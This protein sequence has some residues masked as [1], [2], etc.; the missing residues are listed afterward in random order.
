MT[1]PFYLKD[2]DYTG[3]ECSDSV[4]NAVAPIAGIT[5][6]ELSEKNPD[7]LIF[8][9]SLGDNDDGI[10]DQTLITLNGGK[11]QTGNVL[12]FFG[13]NDIRFFIRS[14]F[15]ESDKQFFL[16]Y[17]LQKVFGINVLNLQTG[18]D[19]NDV[20]DFYLLLFP[21]CL[22]NALR[23]GL[24]KTYRRFSRNDSHLRGTID[25]SR[26]LKENSP[27]KGII[28]YQMRERTADNALTQL[29]RHTIEFIRSNPATASILS[30]KD[31]RLATDEIVSATP[32][33]V[34]NDRSKIIAQ[35]L[36][37][38]RHPYF[39]EYTTLQKLCLKILRH[40]TL[41]FESSDEKTYGIIFDAAWLW[42]EYLA[43]LLKENGFTHPRNKL[44][45]G[46][47]PVYTDGYKVFPDFLSIDY[48]TIIDAKYKKLDNGVSREDRYQMISY[49]HI[50]KADEG[51]FAFPAQ[52]DNSFSRMLQG[53]GG[54]V[55][56]K[57]FI[58]PKEETLTA[59]AAEMKNSEERFKESLKNLF[60]Q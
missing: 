32:S 50:T 28:A 18:I 23:Q 54:T 44:R 14:R 19:Q 3:I 12:G 39:T 36:R 21:Y 27:F 5:I 16:P 25:I 1:T 60:E 41:S 11:I 48:K 55:G 24:F 8:P 42:E 15:D 59:F 51:F 31:S 20:W 30:D 52:E 57:P 40:E 26:H 45:E 2:N 47:I 9:K 33:Y 29:I 17:M 34:R 37:P 10:D 4:R 7:L 22:K 6:R 53:H 38:V 58:I 35:N 49:L 46:G 56:L 13:I 43:T